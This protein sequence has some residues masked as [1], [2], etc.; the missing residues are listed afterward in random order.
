M[1][2]PAA[3]VSGRSSAADSL[4]DEV[5]SQRQQHH[6]EDGAADA[7]ERLQSQERSWAGALRCQLPCCCPV[8]AS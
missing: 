7:K 5:G 4:V 6:D 8:R 3:G 1:A 2:A